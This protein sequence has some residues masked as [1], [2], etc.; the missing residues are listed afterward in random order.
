MSRISLNT[1][2]IRLDKVTVPVALMWSDNDWLADPRNDVQ[3]I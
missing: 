2:Q 1:E 3:H